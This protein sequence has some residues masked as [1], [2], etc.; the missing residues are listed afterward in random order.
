MDVSWRHK[1]VLVVYAEKNSKFDVYVCGTNLDYV[2]AFSMPVFIKCL[3]KVINYLFFR[4][5]V[6]YLGSIFAD[7]FLFLML[8]FFNLTKQLKPL[9]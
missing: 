4:N 3:T 1:L 8:I 7:S 6:Y 5:T 9:G 2:A